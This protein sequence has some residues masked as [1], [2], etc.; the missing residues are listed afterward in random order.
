MTN[1]TQTAGRPLTTAVACMSVMYHSTTGTRTVQ[2]A[3]LAAADGLAGC[4][5]KFWLCIAEMVGENQQQ[6]QPALQQ[7]AGAIDIKFGDPK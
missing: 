1:L 4:Q 7:V 2:V 5:V 6:P 3:V